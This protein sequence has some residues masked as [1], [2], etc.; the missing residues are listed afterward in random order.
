MKEKLMLP[1]KTYEKSVVVVT[2]GA[3]GLGKSMVE[4]FL[5]L[6]AKVAIL[7]RKEENLKK[8]REELSA[9]TNGNIEYF[10]CD[11]RDYAQIETAIAN[12]EKK[13]GIPTV[14]VNNAAGNFVSPTERLTH[15]AFDIVVDI[16]LKG[17][18][19]CTLAMGK[20]WIEKNL[21]GVFLNIVTTY[22][23]TGSGFVVPSACAKAGV[24]TLTKSLAVEW[25]RFGIR[26]NAIAPGPFPTEGAWS[27]LL[28]PPV[29]PLFDPKSKIPLKR[30]GN[31]HE[32]A[33]L[34]TYL[35]SDFAAYINGETVVID[36]G[37]WLQGAGEFNGFLKL[38][39][40]NWDDIERAVRG[41]K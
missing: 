3:T 34:A 39:K 31:H 7:S 36:G 27:R 26:S 37:E 13:L 33:N 35:C 2:G 21:E 38:N 5:H 17:T 20:K 9:S 25:G 41:N 12:I 6:G 23:S 8:T 32:L 14:W 24:E 29:Q 4:A 28:P 1:E 40:E 11:V 22:A 10:I 16:V 18:Y 15:K 19:N 30:F